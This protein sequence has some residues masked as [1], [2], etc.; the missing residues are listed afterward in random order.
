MTTRARL[1]LIKE[2]RIMC[3]FAISVLEVTDLSN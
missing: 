1:Q 2:E 3:T